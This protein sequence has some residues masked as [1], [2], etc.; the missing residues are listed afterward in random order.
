MARSR[1]GTRNMRGPRKPQRRPDQNQGQSSV[2][3]LEPA[4]RGA[5]EIPNSIT[6]KE[7]AELLGVNAADVI[8]ELIKS[9]IFASI[10]QPLDRDTAALVTSE[11][12]YEVAE[13]VKAEAGGAEAK[14]GDAPTPQ[15]AKEVLFEQDDE[16]L[17][18]PRP[19]IVTVMGHVDHG[20]TSLLDA[21]RSSSVAAGERGGIT[22]HIGA[23][24]I[25]KDG[26]RIV[27]L[28]TPVTKRSPPCAR[29]VR[30]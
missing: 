2:Q 10:N 14:N 27:F 5:V 28:D 17:L 16:S 8:R 6:V 15:A 13:A 23:S 19:P 25:D 20:K 12:G 24:E 1:S 7:L 11:L 4:V 30:R 18:Q 22:Q 3:T 9:G 26:R 29:V 21:I